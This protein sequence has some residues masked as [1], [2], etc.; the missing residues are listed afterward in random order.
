MKGLPHASLQT[1]GRLD[2]FFIWGSEGGGLGVEGGSCMGITRPLKEGPRCQLPAI[3]KQP[4]RV[5]HWLCLTWLIRRVCATYVWQESA[6]A[7]V[8]APIV[9][10]ET[11]LLGW[12]IADDKNVC[13]A[14]TLVVLILQCS[15]W[16][17]IGWCKN[18]TE[19]LWS[20]TFRDKSCMILKI[21]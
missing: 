4:C 12:C 16:C 8:T 6:A 7:S 13:V 5:D 20:S 10:F 9:L 3:I 2:L 18:K 21:Q 11:R 19:G 1:K 17:V 14:K 15:V